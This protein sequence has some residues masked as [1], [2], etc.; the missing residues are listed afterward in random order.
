M[1]LWERPVSV[2]MKG[3]VGMAGERVCSDQ[4]WRWPC[5]AAR[6]ETRQPAPERQAIGELQKGENGRDGLLLFR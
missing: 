2:V 1:G 5:R 6:A 4:G 3:L